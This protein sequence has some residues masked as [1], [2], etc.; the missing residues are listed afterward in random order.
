MNVKKIL[1]T[2]V[3]V[4][5]ASIE[6]II[7]ITGVGRDNEA[8]DIF[9]Y[10]DKIK[11]GI[12]CANEDILRGVSATDKEDG[13][14]SDTV[15]I[16]S[17]STIVEGRLEAIKFCACD[18][19]GNVADTKVLFV[20]ENDGT[21]KILDYSAYKVDMENLEY[22]VE[23]ADISGVLDWNKK[24]IQ[25]TDTDNQ[26]LEEQTTESQSVEEQVSEEIQE[27]QPMEEQTSSEKPSEEQTS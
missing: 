7:L 27:S 8:P 19:S 24:E 1:I 4:I 3:V 9:I 10:Q 15:E 21:Y 5:V 6:M 23:G 26:D 13:D 16:V 14:V 25:E 18:K 20:V 11:Y 2:A 22:Q 17:R 12:G